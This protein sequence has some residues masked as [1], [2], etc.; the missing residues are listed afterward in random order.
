MVDSTD[1]Q[2]FRDAVLASGFILDDDPGSDTYNLYTKDTIVI[3]IYV[4][5]FDGELDHFEFMIDQV[6]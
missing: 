6:Y 2:P 1:I 3:G 4:I 5:S